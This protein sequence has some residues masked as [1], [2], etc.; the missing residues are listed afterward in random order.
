MNEITYLYKT[1]YVLVDKEYKP[2]EDLD[3]CYAKES[4]VECLQEN[5]TEKEIANK[6]SILEKEGELIYDIKLSL[7]FVSMTSLPKEI[8]QHYIKIL[9]KY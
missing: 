2:V 5:Y 4:V 9:N 8:Q 6:M 3:T 1:D 7:K